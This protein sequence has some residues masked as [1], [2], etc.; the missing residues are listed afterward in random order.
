MLP[1]LQAVSPKLDELMSWNLEHEFESL[2]LAQ[3]QT[4][5]LLNIAEVRDTIRLT[6]Q[7]LVK[8]KLQLIRLLYEHYRTVDAVL[9]KSGT[10]VNDDM[11]CSK[12]SD[13][14]SCSDEDSYVSEYVPQRFATR[15]RPVQ[16]NQGVGG[17][18]AQFKKVG[19]QVINSRQLGGK[20]KVT[21]IENEDLV[22]E[23]APIA[24][25]IQSRARNTRG[26]NVLPP[27]PIQLPRLI[28][29]PT[30]LAQE[31]PTNY[32]QPTIA[33]TFNNAPMHPQFASHRGTHTSMNFASNPNRYAIHSAHGVGSINQNQTWNN[34]SRAWN[35]NQE[36]GL[37][38]QERS[39]LDMTDQEGHRRTILRLPGDY[40]Q[41]EQNEETIEARESRN[42][43]FRPPTALLRECD[44]LHTGN[45]LDADAGSDA[46]TD[47]DTDDDDIDANAAHSV[48]A[49]GA[50]S[51]FH[52]DPVINPRARYLSQVP[53]LRATDL[54][55]APST[56]SSNPNEILSESKPRNLYRAPLRASSRGPAR[57]SSR[58]P[59]RGSSRGPAGG[60]SLGPSRAPLRSSVE[61][62]SVEHSLSPT[63]AAKSQIAKENGSLPSQA[64][65]D[66]TKEK[67]YPPSMRKLI[68]RAKNYVHIY[69]VTQEPF[70]AIQDPCF[71]EALDRAIADCVEANFHVEKG[72]LNEHRGNLVKLLYNN[73][74]SFRR[75]IKR[76]IRP[77]A[78]EAYGLP[79][80]PADYLKLESSNSA[81]E[82]I[83]VQDKV[84]KLLK[85][86][87]FLKHGKDDLGKT[88]NLANP[89]LRNAVLEAYYKD[90][91]AI[92]RKFPEHF[93]TSIP[94]VGLAFMM[95]V[96]L[97]CI[98]E[99]ENGPELTKKD[100]SAAT[101]SETYDCM[102]GLIDALTA[103][104]VHWNKLKSNRASWAQTGW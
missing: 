66:P 21:P 32:N 71:V 98:E 78:A 88:N 6:E 59:A 51:Y 27:Q 72:Y 73:T 7:Q 56:R 100:L 46:D 92:A 42:I 69:L 54:D 94:R 76:K 1:D 34:F 48:Q 74:S 49:F 19:N 9:D 77:V 62:A 14:L 104:D 11:S 85:D 36:D 90:S 96:L 80:S 53:L 4:S 65:M 33:S 30:S 29:K 95:T 12:G 64:Y 70:P 37:Y 58:G 45:N 10:T 50:N 38:G 25:Q 22:H 63:L 2:S 24:V 91:S 23:M 103:N 43:T 102:L 67:F 89:A 3:N 61:P 86:E 16:T 35:Q 68:R 87:D 81:D 84:E 79:L 99:Y 5:H 31:I 44:L 82:V 60:S 17:A 39:I 57:G 83:L 97:N 55:R 15:V 26:N 13:N 18:D 28:P 52:E 93:S 47:G 41:H 8:Q 20:S 101:Y 40:E 75:A